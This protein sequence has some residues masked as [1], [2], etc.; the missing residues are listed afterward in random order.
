MLGMIFTS[1]KAGQDVLQVQQGQEGLFSFLETSV[2]VQPLWNGGKER[3]VIMEESGVL[4]SLRH[5]LGTS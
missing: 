2:L 5:L 4:G 1:R 3:E